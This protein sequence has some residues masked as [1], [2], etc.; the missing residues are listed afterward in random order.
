[1]ESSSRPEQP[2]T[3]SVKI[4]EDE[5][6]GWSSERPRRD[7]SPAR[8]PNVS[9]RCHVLSPADELRY[10]PG[11]ML[12]IVSASA[13]ERERFAERLLDSRTLLSLD[14]V[15]TLLAGRVS[16]EDMETRAQ[17]VLDTALLKRLQASQT[18][19]IVADGLD[20]GER[21]R[22]VRMAHTA[23]RPR[24]LILL[25]AARDEVDE[26]DLATLNE[27]RRRLD[28]GELGEEGFQTAVRI[29]GSSVFELKRIVFQRPP[30]DD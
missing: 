24:H 8:P 21:E 11:S 26:N 7:G 9:V 18:V 30:R 17:E 22:Y 15:R 19:A 14:K 16:E 3:R 12:V 29:G 20:A 25:E 10:S 27:L 5:R 28:A 1:M 4:G 23:K 2:Q 6:T 13:A